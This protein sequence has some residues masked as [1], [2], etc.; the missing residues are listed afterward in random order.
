MQLNFACCRWCAY[1]NEKHRPGK[2]KSSFEFWFVQRQNGIQEKTIKNKVL[3]DPNRASQ[4][5]EVVNCTKCPPY[6]WLNEKVPWFKEGKCVL[7]LGLH[8]TQYWTKEVI[9]NHLICLEL[10]AK[11]KMYCPH[12][13]S[14]PGVCLLLCITANANCNRRIK[15]MQVWEQGYNLLF[16]CLWFLSTSIASAVCRFDN[17]P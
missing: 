10:T 15:I 8:I 2:Q 1:Q 9:N 4:H 11:I 5:L 14:Y 12:P 17:N 3:W 16:P 13:Q 6:V 7:C